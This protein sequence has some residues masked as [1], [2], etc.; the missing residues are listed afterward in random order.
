M[1]T[2]ALWKIDP[3]RS[4]LRFSV[5]HG[6]IREIAG[7]FRC[8][9]GDVRADESDPR[10]GSVHVW[11]E[12]SSLDTGDRALDAAILRTQLFDNRFE[13][14]LAFHG[15]GF[16]RT[17]GDRLRLTGWLDLHAIRKP[18]TFEIE[19]RPLAVEPGAAPR[20]FCNATGSI[21]RRELGLRG[22]TGAPY[23][24]SDH[25]IGSEIHISAHIEAVRE[26]PASALWR[27]SAHGVLPAA[28]A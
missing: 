2:Q 15:E 13:P 24:L 19:P 16:E 18:I 12:L 11:V 9:G 17:G 25:L 8:W 1:K 27:S 4:T 23:W 22:K 14:A 7:E 6:L 20:F 3:G 10:S 5:R 21:A 26:E 28:L